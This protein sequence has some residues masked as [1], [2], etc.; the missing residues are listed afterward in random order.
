MINSY[1]K[2]KNVTFR[3][4]QPQRK[5]VEIDGDIILGGLISIHEKHENLFCG[6]L[7]P[8]GSVQA[9]EAILFT[10][11]KVNA[12]KDFLPGIKLGAYIMD[13][14]NRDSYSLEQAVNFIQGKL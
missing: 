7:M 14:C 8:N 1:K 2:R 12:E 11:D 4:V 10:L 9:L 6:P 13:D 3:H 5:A